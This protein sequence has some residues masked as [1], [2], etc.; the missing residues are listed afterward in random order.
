MRPSANSDYEQLLGRPLLRPDLEPLRPHFAGKAI[1]VTGAAGSIG[2]ELCSQLLSLDPARLICV[3]RD[4]SALFQLERSLT[5]RQTEVHYVLADSADIA[6]MRKLLLLHN[7]ES[8]FHAAAYKHVS[9]AERDPAAA[10]QNNVFALS[11]LIDVS[12]ESGVRDFLLIS[13]DKAVN[14]VS[15]LGCTK[16]LGELLL[17][18]HAGNMRCVSVRFGN[19]LD[20]QG[21]ALPIFREQL[22]RGQPLTVTH[23]DATRFF[24]TL[25]EAAGLLLHAFTVGR[26]GDVLVLN[27]GEPI[28]ILSLAQSLIRI[29]GFR[30]S[31]PGIVFTSLRPGE[32]LHEELFYEGETR[33]DTACPQ[34]VRTQSRQDGLNLGAALANL[35]SQLDTTDPRDLRRALAA[36]VPQYRFEPEFAAPSH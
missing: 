17:S 20:T 7:I 31:S 22:Q 16:R 30:D 32:K 25:S 21:S 23:Q 13:S 36:V 5:P 26:A 11:R 2:S 18:S 24:M 34:I 12:E 28:S 4:E 15:V 29:G 10:L 9:L 19:V 35:A 1:L 27:V 14:P 33:S 6:R 8:I 3:D